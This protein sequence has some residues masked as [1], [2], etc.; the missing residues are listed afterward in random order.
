MKRVLRDNLGYF[1]NEKKE[2]VITN[3]YPKRP[4]QN[5]VWS[6]LV[7]FNANHF[8]EGDCYASE[9]GKRRIIDSGDRMVFVKDKETGEIYC[10]NRNYN[11]LPFDKHEAHVGVGYHKNVAEYRG[12]ETTLTLTAPKDGYAIQYDVTVENTS[13][14]EKNLTIY[15]YFSP[16]P[17]V[18]GHH[19]YGY[20]EKDE[21]RGGLFYSHV[22]YNVDTEYGFMYFAAEKPFDSYA[23]TKEDF[24][25]AYASFE[26]P[27][28]LKGEK[29]CSKDSCFM[30]AYTAAVSYDI[31]L[32]AGEKKRFTF[33]L[34]IGKTKEEA[35][36]TAMKYATAKSFDISLAAQKAEQEEVF[37]RYQVSLPK[38][39]YMQ[40]L[41]NIWLKRQ[42]SLGKT[43]GRVYGKGFRDR[44][45]DVTAFTA[46]DPE[47]A[48]KIILD[49]LSHQ[50]ENG[51]PI[52]MFEP[53]IWEVYNDGAVWIP[54]AVNTYIKESGDYTILDEV[55]P[56]LEG[57]QA[58]V[59]G[60][61][62]KG[63]EY[64][65]TDVGERGL[66]LFRAG[67][68]NDSTNGAGH[69]GKGESVWTSI[70]TVRALKQFAELCENMGKTNE[71]DAWLKK[72]EI[73][74]ERVMRHGYINGHFI[75]GYDDW[76]NIIGGG[77]ENAES[78]FCINM[79]TWAVLAGIGDEA[80]R[81]DLLD[82]VEE[83]TACAFGYKLANTPYTKPVKGVGRTSYFQPGLYENASVY[84]HANMFKAVADCTMGRADKAFETVEKVTYRHNPKSGVEPYAVT[85]MF[86]GPDC[87]T[88]G[89][90][91]P[92]AWV[93][94]S[95]GWMYRAL[96]EFII[97][98]Q[99]D[100]DGLKILPR[101][102]S[103]WDDFSVERE[104]RGG[105]YALNF[106][107]TGK[108]GVYDGGKKLDG[109][110]LPLLKK[111]ESKTYT[112]EF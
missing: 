59:F 56:Y 72:A 105:R 13:S 52:R 15:P 29:L 51:N 49:S 23:L 106:V 62:V 78:S 89:G 31:T 71:A 7:V 10:V 32:A 37:S 60:H 4:L 35:T 45:Q 68:W 50:R 30:P 54:D 79:Q 73:M 21:T 22:A 69:L 65:T 90:D 86:L 38:D 80:F 25:G 101:I 34:A 87:K 61:I 109:N 85:N 92:M 94:G 99:A 47:T 107:K 41:I 103:S 43:W 111:G 88:R 18:T 9:N 67:D 81:E 28:A 64:L 96:T 17:R 63:L 1:D 58:T 100:Y 14:K 83:K 11:D 39:E 70:A 48:R 19:A 95:A 24:T 2:Y 57:S 42:V 44:L 77:D 27:K 84:V 110:K 26:N 40:T 97:G 93:T 102:P 3:M 55:V 20:A 98:V 104:Y 12:V 6:E 75:H 46:F 74:T 8:G 36:Q 5:Y 53:E 112:I 76:G 16:Y 108:F 66:T 91:A 82:Q 33:A